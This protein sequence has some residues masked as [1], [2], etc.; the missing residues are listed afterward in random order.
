MLI[1]FGKKKN[2]FPF[3]TQ[4]PDRSGTDLGPPLY[5]ATPLFGQLWRSLRLCLVARLC[6]FCPKIA[7]VR[8]E[9]E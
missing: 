8:D 7:K 2:G 1:C 9:Q 4:F 6:N 3:E 5:L